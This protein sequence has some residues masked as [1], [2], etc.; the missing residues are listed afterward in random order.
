MKT[1]P[2]ATGLTPDR[3]R[4]ALQGRYN[5]IRGLTPDVLVQWLDGYHAGQIREAAILWD[6]I[7]RR[8]LVVRGVVGK[9]KE[10]VSQLDWEVVAMD[11]SS[12]AKRHADVLRGFWSGSRATDG[13]RRSVRGG[14]S[15][16]IEQAMDAIGKGYAVHEILWRP[17]ASADPETQCRL[18]AEFVFT[19]LWFFESRTGSLRFLTTDYG[20]DGVPLEDHGW[21]VHAANGLMEATSVAY[22]YKNLPLRDWLSASEKFGSPGVIAR[23]SSAVDSPEWDAVQEFV[24]AYASDFG[25]VISKE[26]EVTLLTPPTSDG[27][28]KTL[29]D[30]MDR[31]IAALWRGGDLSTLSQGGDSNGAS[32]Q[33]D[34]QEAM[35]AGDVRRMIEPLNE[36]VEPFVIAYHFGAGVKP[37]AYIRIIIPGADNTDRDLKVDEFLSR[38]GVPLAIAD[39]AERYGRRVADAGEATLST[40]APAPAIPGG[41]GRQPQFANDSALQ[42]AATDDIARALADALA[43]VRERLQAI[44]RMEDP[45]AQR[46]ALLGLRAELPSILR[47]MRLRPQTAQQFERLFGAA[48]VNGLMRGPQG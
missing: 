6:A 32:L 27:P 47:Q 9:R 48:M 22:L 33:G 18:T 5:P 19:P 39:A 31:R 11:D 37:R 7:E 24:N 28:Q 13:L 29:V 45:N 46:E 44:Q 17:Q 10:A 30:Y 36:Q 23:T 3:V 34:E 41:F 16:L 4:T 2:Q 35:L 38:Q 43:P 40:P 12:E 14:F 20:Y 42:T 25:G 15:Q 21:V 1:T 8:D 26:T